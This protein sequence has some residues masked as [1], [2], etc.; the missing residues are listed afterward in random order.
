[1]IAEKERRSTRR[2]G[3]IAPPRPESYSSRRAT[4][5]PGA[6]P[7]VVNRP[8]AQPVGAVESVRLRESPGPMAHRGP[9]TLRY[10]QQFA[11]KSREGAAVV[12]ASFCV[13]LLCLYVAAYARVTAEGFE[14]SQLRKDIKASE[15]ESEALRAEI[16]RLTLPD[17][18]KVRAIQAGMVVGTP[19]NANFLTPRPH[20]Q[21]AKAIMDPVKLVGRAEGET[22]ANVNA[23]P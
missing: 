19:G 20:A 14:I 23:T 13:T 12:V 7:V 17:A 11:W 9:R 5:G 2:G 22:A 10:A 8:A 1:M 6:R 4:T 15:A 18:V 16:S 3:T 21:V